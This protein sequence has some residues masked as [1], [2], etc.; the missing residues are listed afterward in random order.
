MPAA[1]I[2]EIRRGADRS[3]FAAAGYATL[4][5]WS[6][7]DLWWIS[8]DEDGAFCARGI[9]GQVLW[10]DPKAEM[11]IARF[12][13][14]PLA[15]NSNLDPTS[16]PAFAA[17]GNYLMRASRTRIPPQTLAPAKQLRPST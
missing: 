6:Y 8:H 12:A 1:A 14:F 5:G 16:L 15:A 13:S 7:H 4:P 17:L 3:Q 10:I 2:A 11:V 9:H